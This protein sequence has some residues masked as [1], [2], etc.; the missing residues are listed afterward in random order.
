VARGRTRQRRTQNSGQVINKAVHPN[1]GAMADSPA[2][3]STELQARPFALAEAIQVAT[4]E[5]YGTGQFAPLTRD[6]QDDSAF[7]PMSP[8]VPEAIDALNGVGRTDP[9]TFQ[10][11]TGWNLPGNGNREVPWQVLRAAANGIGVMRRCIEVRKKHVR[12]LK[13]AFSVSEEAVNDAHQSDPSKGRMETERELRERL[14]PEMNR[15]REY[16]RKPW[17]SNDVDMGA[18][19]NAVME[20]YLV[21]DGVAIFPRKTYGGDV[22]DLEVID[23]TTIKL[24][25]DTRG[26][27]PLPPHPAFQQVLYGFPRG[28]WTASAEYDKDGN[29]LVS[30]A[31]A[32]SELYYR[33]ENFRT[34]S[35]YGFSPTEMALFD[36]RLYLQRQKWMLAEYDDGST[37]LT[38]IET[39]PAADGKTLTLAQ[40]RLWEKAF[41]AKHAGQTK[42]RMRAKVMP[43]GWKAVQMTTMDERYKPEY[44]LHL[45]KL[46]CSY[47]GVPIA[48]LGFTEPTGL[49]NQSWHE[50]QAEVSGR[51]GLR[52]DTEVMTDVVND[53]SRQFIRMPVEIEFRFV[54][55]A[56]AN[57]GER[58]TVLAGQ[59]T[60]GSISV[61]EERQELGQSLL[62]F[63][64]ADMYFL[65]TPTGPIF[66]EGSY[67]RAQQAVEQAKMQTQAQVMG[68]AGKLEIEH[69]R[70]ED[71][72]AARAEGRDFAREQFQARQGAETQGDNN[73]TQKSTEL[74]AWRNWRRK[75]P[76]DEPKRPFLFKHVTPDDGWPELEGLTP[77]VVDFGSD[78]QWV[79]EDDLTKSA[80]SWLEWNLRHPNRPRDA[81]GR[82]VK[83]STLVDAL[84]DEEKRHAKADHGLHYRLAGD[85]GPKTGIPTWEELGR[86]EA[87]PEVGTRIGH[88]G[89][90]VERLP[91]TPR[92]YRVINVEGKDISSRV[93]TTHTAGGENRGSTFL[94]AITALNVDAFERERVAQAHESGSVSAHEV[95]PVSWQYGID[96][97]RGLEHVSPEERDAIR[98]ALSRWAGYKPAYT[99]GGRSEG[100]DPDN[101]RMSEPAVNAAIR[102]VYPRTEQVERDIVALDRAHALSRI[103]KPITVYR[104]FSN[105]EHVLPEDWRERDLKGLSFHIP[106]YTP[107]SGNREAAADYIGQAESRGF[108]IRI[109]LP[110]G[111][112][113]LGIRDDPGGMDDEGEILLPRGLTF[114]VTKDH[115]RDEEGLRWLDVSVSRA[116]AKSSA[117][118]RNEAPASLPR[119]GHKWDWESIQSNNMT[120]HGDSAS[121]NLAQAL[122]RAGRED[123][124]QYVADMR[125]RISDPQGEHSPED[126]EKMVADLKAMMGRESDAG[127]RAKYRRALEDIDA[128][129]TPVPD[130]PDSTPSALRRMVE[131]LNMIPNA[132]RSGHFAGSSQNASAV[133]RVVA[134]IREA[135]TGNGGSI[136]T[137]EMA[138]RDAL[139]SLHESVDGA[140]QMWRLEDLLKDPEIRT[141]VRSHYPNMT[142]A[143]QADDADPKAQPQQPEPMPPDQ[144]WPGW[145]LDATIAAIVT[146]MLLAAMP[147]LDI[148]AL[149]DAFAHWSRGYQS[150]DPV[151][152]V[153]LWIRNLPPGV[154]PDFEA[155]IR[156]ALRAAHLEG[157][158]V[159]ERSAAALL[160]FVRDGGDPREPGGFDVSWDGW[161][162]GHPSAAEALL[163]PGGLERLL[164]QSNVV[165]KGI[166]Q[167]RMNEL[168]RV[169][170]QGMARGDAPETIA[171]A[172]RTEVLNNPVW[173]R[174]VAITETNRASSWAT[175]ISYRN[176]GLKYKGWMTAFDQR[177]C[178][179]CQTNEW[180]APGVPR[181]VPID[182]L[183]PSG[184][185][186]PPAH[187]ICRCA[188]IP[189]YEPFGEW[190]VTKSVMSW[191][192]WNTKHPK[193][194][195][196]SS[197]RFGVG[198]GAK[199]DLPKSRFKRRL[200]DVVRRA[201]NP[202][203]G[204]YDNITREEYEDITS[205]LSGTYGGL[206]VHDY[207]VVVHQSGYETQMAGNI[208]DPSGDVVIGRFER[209]Y[210][211]DGTGRIWAKH[212]NLTLNP[213]YRGQG[214]AQEFN[215]HLEQC[216]RESGVYA[217]TL[218]AD[219]DVGGYAWA[220]AGYDWLNE[221]AA[222][223]VRKRLVYAH[224][225][226]DRRIAP[227]R[228][229]EQQRLGAQMLA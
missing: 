218:T 216:N 140:M 172:L 78:W 228:R 42:E 31:Y 118:P 174:K 134:I 1:F 93:A 121:M 127:L 28:E 160:D 225:R 12:T 112:P 198:G 57:T 49:G 103:D 41:N 181:I 89:G 35:P 161:T 77:A 43:N 199:H 32:A 229:E 141:W 122:H 153:K 9:R 173:A 129:A 165:I 114:R 26:A 56:A 212:S 184:D 152:D 14:L 44:D 21:L 105:G 168:G 226:K 104:G 144:R 73:D 192:E 63:K 83:A 138:I 124:A 209:T 136:G 100:G 27:R 85:A 58:E 50:G 94:D 213:E 154:K 11:Q 51:L 175:V 4:G 191:L 120:M 190:D 29:E 139:H 98:G 25:L 202:D 188:T 159:G 74:V 119:S 30:D 222:Q 145:L 205:G 186:W 106:Q 22:Y 95:I 183:F 219:I 151:P 210:Y 72:A 55:P 180:E 208:Y 110:K 149:I 131:E 115:G 132:R 20:D 66:L 38:W 148:S 178:V 179:I 177:V 17:K 61:N 206:H 125:Y 217:I 170:G 19:I 86:P 215:A 46:L 201:E 130:L 2:G 107:T 67:D 6:P 5:I 187:P 164:Y 195:R 220:R 23:A 40:A 133:D 227:E 59:R 128:L 169:L 126:V 87:P 33:R 214:F 64:E 92:S 53:L 97:V 8:L 18:F 13:W 81:R 54:D 47:Y 84:R 37:P 167:S 3:R 108:G 117:T 65:T 39:A 142:K 48:E 123:D 91:G 221:D 24:L 200:S 45:I 52:P 150:G 102:G 157:T 116:K 171:R 7:G 156:P 68:A 82:W 155:A 189:V 207:D 90:V 223:S 34:F 204:D 16:W 147:G 166:A 197:G 176:A 143:A 70:L 111:F 79:I 99:A 109:K 15:L 158:L 182:E 185:P 211:D 203:T 101:T 146:K 163:E 193:H 224:L 135:D 80:M 71:G 137:V 96:Q 113:A 76:E 10:Y 60:R 62:P 88:Q 194:P 69:K 36:A 162:P 196:I 75:H